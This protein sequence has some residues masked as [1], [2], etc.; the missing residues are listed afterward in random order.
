MIRAASTVMAARLG[1]TD[2]KPSGPNPGSCMALSNLMGTVTVGRLAVSSGRLP[3]STRCRTAMTSGLRAAGVPDGVSSLISSTLICA[4]SVC[5]LSTLKWSMAPR[6]VTAAA[7]RGTVERRTSPRMS[8][9]ATFAR[10]VT[11]AL[12]SVTVNPSRMVTDTGK[13]TSMS[14]RSSVS[15]TL[16]ST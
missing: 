14:E 7:T 16:T 15:V 1:A 11:W 13:A 3:S 8:T 4:R 5:V 9:R 10:K 6:N 2:K 12:L